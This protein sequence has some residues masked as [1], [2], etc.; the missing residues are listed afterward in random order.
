MIAHL[1]NKR[2]RILKRQSRMD[3]QETLTTLGTYDTQ[4]NK[5]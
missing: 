2:K 4:T 1:V 5:R 3:N